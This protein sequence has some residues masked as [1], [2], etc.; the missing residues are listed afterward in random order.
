MTEDD[1]MLPPEGIRDELRAALGHN[2]GNL[3][4]VFGLME[5]GVTSNSDLV[6]RGGGSGPGAVA[7]PRATIRAVPLDGVIP[8]GPS[9]ATMAGRSLGGLLRGQPRT[10][11]GS[12]ESSPSPS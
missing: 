8:N 9:V 11:R 5:Q 6:A 10:K 7:N 3:G 2:V 1:P 12:G 4:R